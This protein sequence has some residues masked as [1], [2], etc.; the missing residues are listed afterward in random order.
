[1]RPKRGAGVVEVLPGGQDAR[2]ARSRKGIC[3][4]AGPSEADLKS[5]RR[6]IEASA[7]PTDKVGRGQLG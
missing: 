4:K 3:R 5:A 7:E 6:A 1:M 2:V